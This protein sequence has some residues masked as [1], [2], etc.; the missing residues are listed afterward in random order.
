MASE[1]HLQI[2]WQG[3]AAW[4]EWRLKNPELIPDLSGADFQR[5]DL[6]KVDLSKTILSK[7]D[8]A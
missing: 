4:N 5:A 1:E 2:I 3:V 7:A 8:L 6:Y